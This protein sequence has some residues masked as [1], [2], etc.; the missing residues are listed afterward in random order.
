[1]NAD[2]DV[3]RFNSAAFRLP[4]RSKFADDLN[5]IQIDLIEKI[6]AA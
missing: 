3:L 1:M 5:N 6:G 4:G 2:T